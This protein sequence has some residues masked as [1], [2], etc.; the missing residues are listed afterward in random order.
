MLSYQ[1]LQP[2]GSAHYCFSN[3]AIA[4]LYRG[5]HFFCPVSLVM[6]GPKKLKLSSHEKTT[7]FPVEKEYGNVAGTKAADLNAM[8]TGRE[9]STSVLAKLNV[10]RKIHTGW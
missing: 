9:T 2:S 8:L 4:F 5:L 10:E 6:T 1:Y 3:P 7:A